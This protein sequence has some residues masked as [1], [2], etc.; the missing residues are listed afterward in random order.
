M[1]V[2]NKAAVYGT[3]VL[4]ILS[5]VTHCNDLLQMLSGYYY[6]VKTEDRTAHQVHIHSVTCQLLCS[7]SPGGCYCERAF[8]FG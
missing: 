4:S 6:G 3:A 8:P 5:Q 2:S 1:F 7:T